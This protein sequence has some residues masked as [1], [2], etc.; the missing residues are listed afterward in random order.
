MYWDRFDICEAYCVLE[1]DYNN[2][3]WVRERPRNRRC[4]EATSIQLARIE[5]SPRM[6]LCFDS[7]TE[8]GQEIYRALE[9]RYGF[10]VR[11]QTAE[12]Q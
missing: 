6:D 5:F 9:E 7:L 1:W 11:G 12:A 4:M 8:N 3:G 10:T 2:G